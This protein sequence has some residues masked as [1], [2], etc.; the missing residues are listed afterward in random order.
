M[1]LHDP[2]FGNNGVL[3]LHPLWKSRSFVLACSKSFPT[4]W[5]ALPALNSRSTSSIPPLP[6]QASTSHDAAMQ[7]RS[8]HSLAI[9]HVDRATTCE[10]P[11]LERRSRS[12]LP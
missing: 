6:P 2:F 5:R 10:E 9:T 7:P 11:L 4:S 8:P 3:R 12:E 1:L